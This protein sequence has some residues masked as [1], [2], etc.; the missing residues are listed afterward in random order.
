M[1]DDEQPISV[2]WRRRGGDRPIQTCANSGYRH[3]TN[4]GCE[5]EDKEERAKKR[6]AAEGINPTGLVWRDNM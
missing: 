4:W 2:A 6:K 3:G 5:R 1:L